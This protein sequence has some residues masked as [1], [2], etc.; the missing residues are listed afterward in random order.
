[1]SGIGT[2]GEGPLHAAL[3]ALFREP[4]DC[5]E[6]PVGGYVVDL[7][8]PGELVEIQ[9]RGFSRL[10]AKLEALLPEHR[11]RVVYPLAHETR[12]R[13]VEALPTGGW[14]ELSTRR[15]P[16]KRGVWHAFEELTS[17]APWLCHPNFRLEVLSLRV[18]ESRAQTGRRVWRRQGW[19]VVERRL[20]EVFDGK[21]FAGGADWLALLPVGLPEEFGTAE[22][23]EGAGV[24]R[25]LAQ[26]AC[27]TLLGAGLLERSG[28]RGN[29]H[30]Y[31][32]RETVAARV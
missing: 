21:L 10:K 2:L 8:R 15:S 3:K 20:D 24:P 14:R 32:R 11:V 17:I 30:L 19:E 9:T 18:V 7:V 12:I 5:V 13:K 16:L 4:G 1:M 31:R 6:V 25:D 26:K 22:L 27:Y 23:A 29:A 28:K